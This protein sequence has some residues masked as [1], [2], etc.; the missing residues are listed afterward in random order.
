MY[1]E[2]KFV[3]VEWSEVVIGDLVRAEAE[4]L[5]PVDLILLASSGEGGIAFIETASL[6]G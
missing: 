1:R 4:D 5:F 2:G 6:D 3:R